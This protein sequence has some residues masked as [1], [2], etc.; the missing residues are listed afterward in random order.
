MSGPTLIR[1]AKWCRDHGARV[2]GPDQ[3]LQ[4]SQLAAIHAHWT[5]KIEASSSE[6]TG[7]RISAIAVES[8]PINVHLVCESPL[9]K[10]DRA[11]VHAEAL[12]LQCH[13]PL[14]EVVANIMPPIVDGPA[15]QPLEGA[16]KLLP[17]LQGPS[18]AGWVPLAPVSSAKPSMTDPGHAP[19][20]GSLTGGAVAPPRRSTEQRRT[21]PIDCSAMTPHAFVEAARGY[22]SNWLAPAGSYPPRPQRRSSV[23]IDEINETGAE[24][25]NSQAPRSFEPALPGS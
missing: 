10:M 24:L 14:E 15:V 25:N 1:D 6:D 18:P 16:P 20:P 5:A 17:A 12:A 22:G 7:P 2:E 11:I 3:A 8:N 9:F 13:D 23:Q 21:E 4:F 19:P